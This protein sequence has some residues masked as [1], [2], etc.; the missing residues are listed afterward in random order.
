MSIGVAT[1]PDHAQGEQELMRRAD[2]ALY[3]AKDNGRDQ[4]RLWQD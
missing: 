1:F 2:A 4:V 3:Q